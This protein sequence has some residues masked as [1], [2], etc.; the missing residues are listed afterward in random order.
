MLTLGTEKN[1]S[2]SHVFIKA[3]VSVQRSGKHFSRQHFEI[4]T[5]KI[6]FAFMQIVSHEISNPIFSK[7]IIGLLSDEFGLK[8]SYSSKIDILLSVDNI[9]SEIR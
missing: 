4:V 6:G 8:T 1:R 2:I 9:N 5:Q 7:D 3:L